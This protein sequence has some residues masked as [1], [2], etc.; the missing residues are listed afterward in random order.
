MAQR[1]VT[2]T[3][4]DTPIV[5]TPQSI[6][7]VTANQ[8]RDTASNTLDQALTYSAG[9]RT[10]IY[11]ASSRMDT[12]QARG[13]EIEDIFLDGLKDRV[14]FWTSPPRVA[15]YLMERMEVL[16]GPAIG[17]PP[18]RDSVCQTVWDPVC[19]GSLKK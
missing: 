1:S 10:S 7:V 18:C 16:R 19:A 12:A 6:S 13:V 2:A 15:P 17:R 9:V 3:K 4:T 5:E 8:I 11:G 14:N